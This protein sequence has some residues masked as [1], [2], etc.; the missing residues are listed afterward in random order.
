[1]ERLRTYGTAGVS[2]AILALGLGAMYQGRM[3]GSAESKSSRTCPHHM[4]LGPQYQM[5]IVSMSFTNRLEG[6]LFR[7]QI[8][9]A[10]EQEYRFAL[11][12][13]K[14]TKPAGASLSLAAADLTLHYYHGDETEVAP[15]E[16][17]SWFKSNADSDA[18]I[19]MS[20][21]PGPGFIK[22]TTDPAGTSGT[23]VYI[24]AVFSYMEPDTRE[25][26]ICIGHPTTAEPFVC[27]APAWKSDDG[28]QETVL[29]PPIRLPDAKC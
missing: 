7:R 3:P 24:D 8:P 28:I 10:E 11:V 2:V 23:V 14:I 13:L 20:L 21:I 5:E 16:G 19:L 17:L 25:C 6:P 9:D 29:E 12:T 15:C 18:S 4:Q 1:M 27:P 22:Q 26:W